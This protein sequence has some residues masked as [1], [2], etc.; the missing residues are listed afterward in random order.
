MGRRQMKRQF[1]VDPVLPLSEDLR[2]FETLPRETAIDVVSMDA[3]RHVF[4]AKSP[5]N[6]STIGQRAQLRFLARR[7]LAGN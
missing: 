4:L 2:T 3:D 7:Q 6:L 1:S 5:L